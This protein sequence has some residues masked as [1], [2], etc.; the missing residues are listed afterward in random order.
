ISDSEG[1][2][3]HERVRQTIGQTEARLEI[4]LGVLPE[5]RIGRNNHVGWEA[6]SGNTWGDISGIRAAGNRPLE[7][8]G[9]VIEVNFAN[10]ADGILKIAPQ[11]IR[12]KIVTQANVQRQAAGGLP[13]VDN[14]PANSVLNGG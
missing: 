9:S 1:S 2:A 11:R 5:P 4:R 13:L 6:G 3:Q 12:L 7:D 14:I 8:V 10:G